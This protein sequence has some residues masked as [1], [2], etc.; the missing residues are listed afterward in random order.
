LNRINRPSKGWL[1]RS[2]AV[3]FDTYPA[4]TGGRRGAAS[5]QGGEKRHAPLPRRTGLCRLR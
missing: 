2:I 1:V 4:G 5:F 3:L